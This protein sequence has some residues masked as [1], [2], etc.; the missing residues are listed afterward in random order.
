MRE[1]LLWNVWDLFV[2]DNWHQLKV[3]GL[4]EALFD[5]VHVQ[6]QPEC[7]CCPRRLL[8]EF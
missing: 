3:N 7:E 5:L 1:R 6:P 8:K 4:V 2:F